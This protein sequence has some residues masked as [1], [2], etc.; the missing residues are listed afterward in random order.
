MRIAAFRN[1]F[2]EKSPAVHPKLNLIQLKLFPPFSSRFKSKK[3]SQLPFASSVLIAVWPWCI[4]PRR[5]H[6]QCENAPTNI[7]TPTCSDDP[8]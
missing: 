3:I 2:V 7:V 6:N 1:C 8:T 4:T 5:L